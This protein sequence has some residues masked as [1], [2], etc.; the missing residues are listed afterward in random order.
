LRVESAFMLANPA[1]A[2]GV[3]AASAPPAI[4][5]SAAPRCTS[6]NAAPRACADDAHAE[7]VQ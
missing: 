3:I 6:R 2:S 5:T 1:T 7:T 4:I